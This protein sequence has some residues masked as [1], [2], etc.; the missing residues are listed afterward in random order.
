M[1]IPPASYNTVMNHAH[2]EPST[3][4]HNRGVGPGWYVLR[5][6]EPSIAEAVRPGQF[7]QILC[8]ESEATD[9]LLRRPF[10]V[11]QADRPRGTYDV[12][13]TTV[14]R[15]TRWMAELRETSDDGRP[16]RVDVEGPFGNTFTAPRPGE[17]AFLVAGGVGVAPL[18]FLAREILLHGAP[19][20]SARPELVLCMG[21]RSRGLLQGIEEFR[22]LPM[23]IHVATDDGSEGFRGVV[24]GL[25][26]S[27]LERERDPS[28]VR[29]YGCGPQ[30]MNESLRA[31]LVERGIAGEICLESLMACGFGICFGCVAPIRKEVGGEYYNRRI[32]WEGPVFDARLLH[33]GIEA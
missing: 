20:G 19:E 30:G 8:A 14:G 28:R 1:D 18:Y 27:L 15:G 10:S 9:P 33:P 5:L 3:V 25:L 21:A 23:E 4:I 26:D 11:Y 13:Y 17:R 16:T 6:H 32:C 24:T 2:R 12:L 22:A 31:L 7:V 29:V